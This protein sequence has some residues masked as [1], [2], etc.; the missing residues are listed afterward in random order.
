L[1]STVDRCLALAVLFIVTSL[2][3]VVCTWMS[4]HDAGM[5]QAIDVDTARFFRHSTLLIDVLWLAV[6]GAALWLRW[7]RTPDSALLENVTVQL[8]SGNLGL[9]GHFLGLA[10][11]PF[12]LAQL[13]ALVTGLLLFRRGPVLAGVATCTV[14]ALGAAV[15]AHLGWFPYGP[16]FRTIPV[17]DG[18]IAPFFHFEMML[19][20]VVTVVIVLGVFLFVLRRLHD[21]EAHLEMLSKTDP[22][23]G[24][25]NRR[26]FFEALEREIG[27]AER[28]RAPLAVA[29]LDLDHFKAINDGH[30]HLAGDAV[31]VAAAGRLAGELRREDVLARWG[32]E[33]FVLL[34][35]DTDADGARV[36]A[37]RCRARLHAEPVDFEGTAI[38]VTASFGVAARLAGAAAASGEALVRAA[39]EALYRAKREGRNRV[40][41]AA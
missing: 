30:G 4:E 19:I 38:E 41:V 28:R 13:G 34:L 31:L 14:I 32:G 17:V 25:T 24:I 3:F 1:R 18:H 40:E 39:D 36:V 9:A 22:L 6:A 15:G 12:A 7:R 37:E 29:I 8:V 20:V 35:P 16:L 26:E 33:E 23:T 11:T 2:L 5:A 21:R 10:T 27:R